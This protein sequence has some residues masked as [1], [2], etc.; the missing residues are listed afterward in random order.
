MAPQR[1]DIDV[2]LVW[3]EDLTFV[4]VTVAI[5]YSVTN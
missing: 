1:L 2:Y 4:V 5:V 3:R